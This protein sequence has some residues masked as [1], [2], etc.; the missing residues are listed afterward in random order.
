MTPRL[1][2]IRAEQVAQR[3]L[4]RKF[5]AGYAACFIGGWLLAQT[6]SALVHAAQGGAAW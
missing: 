1:E 2:H 4:I 6:V 5:I 3:G